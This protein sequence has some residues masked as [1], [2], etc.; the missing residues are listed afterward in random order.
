MYKIT[1]KNAEG[2]TY[3]FFM[4]SETPEAPNPSPEKVPAPPNGTLTEGPIGWKFCPE[5]LPNSGPKLPETVE[6]MGKEGST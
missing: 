6:E 2:S 5:T 1:V 3:T 4:R